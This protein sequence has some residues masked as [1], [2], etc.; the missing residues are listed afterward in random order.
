MNTNLLHESQII[1]TTDQS[2]AADVL[3][4]PQPVLV[5]FWAP[6]CGPCR[7]LTPVLEE[8][9]VKYRGRIGIAKVNVDENPELAARFGISSIPTLLYFK[10]GHLVDQS[11]GV[12][13]SRALTAKLDALL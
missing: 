9:A 12:P 8:L 4:A 7:M 13:S 5:D 3:G 2:F 6:W 1:A 11:V 10:G